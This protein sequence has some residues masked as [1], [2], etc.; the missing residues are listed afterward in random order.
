MCAHVHTSAR[1]MCLCVCLYVHEGTVCGM[2]LCMGAHVH[3]SVDTCKHWHMW[4][5]SQAVPTP[6]VTVQFPGGE[7]TSRFSLKL[8][9]GPI[10]PGS[11]NER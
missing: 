2:C 10:F 1:G 7:G 11:Q 9:G 5:A 4:C 3:S 6:D 8:L